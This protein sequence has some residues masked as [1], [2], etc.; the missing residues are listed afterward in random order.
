MNKTLKG[1]EVDLFSYKVSS[2][3]IEKLIN[4]SCGQHFEVSQLNS[5]QFSFHIQPKDYC[6]VNGGMMYT[7]AGT[8]VSSLN[9]KG[10]LVKELRAIVKE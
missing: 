9:S 3:S 1:I 10:V 8:I 7:S 5:S 6:L 4:E 2:C